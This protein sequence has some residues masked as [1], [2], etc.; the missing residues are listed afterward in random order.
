MHITDWRDK[1]RLNSRVGHR[2]QPSVAWSG[3]WSIV[4]I[5]NIVGKGI[6]SF[7][8]QERHSYWYRN[9]SHPCQKPDAPIGWSHGR[10]LSFP[11][12]L[13]LSFFSLS[14]S[15]CSSN[16]WLSPSCVGVHLFPSMTATAQG[17]LFFVQNLAIHFFWFSATF[18]SKKLCIS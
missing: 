16:G 15:V 4:S 7:Q 11:P 17:C 9:S 18:I 5:V 8:Q 12:D 3:R 2:E 14:V 6:L 10:L 13:A 1:N